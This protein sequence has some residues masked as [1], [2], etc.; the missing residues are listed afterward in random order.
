MELPI[1]TGILATL[2]SVTIP[3]T[4]VVPKP[5]T[6]FEIGLIVLATCDPVRSLTKV[7]RPVI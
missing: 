1:E 5:T 4:P 3:L 7:E 2:I 6:R